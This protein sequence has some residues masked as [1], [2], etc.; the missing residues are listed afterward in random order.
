M[1]MM[2]GVPCAY[3]RSRRIYDQTSY[4]I[5]WGLVLNVFAGPIK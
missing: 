2:Y 5:F 3:N 1:Y 4:T